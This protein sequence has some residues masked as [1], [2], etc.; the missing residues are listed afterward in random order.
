M[1]PQSNIEAATGFGKFDRQ[2]VRDA[3]LLNVVIK[4]RLMDP[5][6]QLVFA[7]LHPG[8]CVSAWQKNISQLWNRKMV[9]RHPGLQKDVKLRFI[10]Q[11]VN[12]GEHFPVALVMGYDAGSGVKFGDRLGANPA[13]AGK[14]DLY[15]ALGPHS[16]KTFAAYQADEGQACAVGGTRTGGLF[17][18]LRTRPPPT[19]ASRPKACRMPSIAVMAFTRSLR[20]NSD[21]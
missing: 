11:S 13:R 20:T 10:L 8:S 12:A 14:N 16:N 7:G 19:F 15:L 6:N 1:D 2:L 5:N 21:T 4:V 18:S 9:F 17:R 3:G